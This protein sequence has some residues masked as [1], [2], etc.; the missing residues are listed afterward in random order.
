MS[1]VE[2]YEATARMAEK[3]SLAPY[4]GEVIYNI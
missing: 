2:F 4:G 1:I 3:I